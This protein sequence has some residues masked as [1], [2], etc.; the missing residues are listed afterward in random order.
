M[1]QSTS[2]KEPINNDFN[3]YSITGRIIDYIITSQ[4]INEINTIFNVI[5]SNIMDREF[6][7]DLSTEVFFMLESDEVSIKPGK[8]DEFYSF[9]KVRSQKIPKELRF[10]KLLFKKHSLRLKLLLEFYAILID[11]RMLYSGS[12]P[13]KKS[14]NKFFKGII[15]EAERRNNIN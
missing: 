12:S 1:V 4:E 7:L 10:S 15:R 13:F 6:A 11:I 9:F 2:F 14:D 3:G 5:Q 8:A